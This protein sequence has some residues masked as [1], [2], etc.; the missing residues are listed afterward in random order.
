MSKPILQA[1]RQASALTRI[2]QTSVREMDKFS[3]Q[4][5]S[6]EPVTLADYGAQALICRVLAEQFPSDAVIAEESGS[7]FRHLASAE[8]Q[9]NVADLLS[10]TLAEPVTP[11]DIATWLDF[12]KGVQAER[13]WIIDPIDGTRGFIAGRHYAICI[14]VL[15][16]E[17]LTGGYM[18]CPAYEKQMGGAL[19][20]VEDGQ[21]WRASLEDAMPAPQKVQVSRQTDRAQMRIVQSYERAESIRQ[22]LQALLQ[23]AGLGASRLDSVDSM[24]KY[25]LVA[26]G[27]AD[28]L[29]RLWDKEAPRPKMIWD[30]AAGVALVQ[31]AGGQASDMDG[32]PLIFHQGNAMPNRGFLV[33]SGVAHS[34]LIEAAQA[35]QE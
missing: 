5:Q 4:K 11:D 25:A 18:A 21:T 20:Y 15:E 3:P 22:R 17:A 34:A 2:I 6:S 27:D 1:L 26:C 35:L 7:Q 33:S 29:L 9:Q 28:V 12:G 31:Y 14:G 13:T 19:F 8:Q 10:K 16:G 24:E 32:S 30:H 23:Q